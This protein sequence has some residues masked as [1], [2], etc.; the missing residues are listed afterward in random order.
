MKSTS[1]A[2]GGRAAPVVTSGTEASRTGLA[3]DAVGAAE[4]ARWGW[5]A[6]TDGRA[7]TVFHASTAEVITR[8]MAPMTAAA[9]WT[10]RGR[11][12]RASATLARF[13]SLARIPTAARSAGAAEECVLSRARLDHARLSEPRTDGLVGALMARNWDHAEG[14]VAAIPM[15][16]TTNPPTAS[17]T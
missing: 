1:G 14:V 12:N 11:Q 16:R 2:T 5:V 6:P 13:I 17:R 15:P 7:G 9:T 3:A 10:R 4:P 8:A